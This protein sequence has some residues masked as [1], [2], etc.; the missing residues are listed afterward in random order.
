MTHN[1]IKNLERLLNPRH[2]AIIGGRD[3]EVVI[4]ECRRSGYDGPIWPVNPNREQIGGLRC[5]KHIQDLPAPPDAV[6]LAVPRKAAIECIG[7]LRDRGAGGVVCYTAGFGETGDAGAKAEK[8]LIEA[9]GD[10]ALVGPNCYGVINYHRGLALWPFA[11]GGHH[12]GFGAAIV[13]QSG[14]FSSD[15]TM[16]QR[17]L[18]LSY[19]VSAGN[20]S[21]LRLEDFVNAFIEQDHVRAIGLHIEG[22]PDPAGFEKVALR[23]LACDIPIVALKTGSSQIGSQLTISH[24]GS[25]SGT[26]KT[27]SAFFDRLGIIRAHD[28]SHFL[29]T[30]K[31]LCVAGKPS[32]RRLA[33][34]TCSGG[35]ATMLADYAE[36]LGLSF[37]QPSTTTKTALSA[38]LP[39][40]ATV[41]NPLDYTTP[42]WGIT[43]KTHPV[44][45]ATL[46]DGYDA[47]VIVQDYPAAGLDESKPYYQ[48]DADSFIKA[49]S[50][51]GIPSAICSTIHEN[52]DLETRN[53]LITHNVAPMQGINECLHAVAAA[54]NYR[55]RRDEIM[56]HPAVELYPTMPA[57]HKTYM[58]NELAG[59]QKLANS[60]VDIPA[61]EHIH[62]GDKLEKT[63]L[64]FPL[65]LK[66]LSPDLAHKTEAGAVQLG[67]GDIESLQ[68]SV[69]NMQSHIRHTNPF[70]KQDGFLIEEMVSDVI[71]ELMVSVRR[72]PQFGLVLMLSSGGIMAEL[73]DDATTLIL[74]AGRVSMMR[75]L[76]SLRISKLIEGYRGKG[77]VDKDKLL[78]CLEQIVSV[79]ADDPAI[80]EIEIN[81][82]MLTANKI[83]AVDAVVTCRE[84]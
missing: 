83:V 79:I 80:V 32:G 81:P 28:P 20:Q 82:I 51:A 8:S 1:R 17:S 75:A 55:E 22:L 71:A 30:L 65:A 78:D 59:K 13:T 44:F 23:A 63:A 43:E 68:I 26:D 34:F 76:A 25:M 12:P 77:S 38:L 14:M 42:I 54:T 33:G 36:P 24:T 61:H 74:P 84:I 72:D 11:H 9:A 3:A 67:I 66:F 39:H 47:A 45:V 48:S 70:I 69:A 4:K 53:Y 49:T 62:T 57:P 19:M 41:S 7:D 16:S 2:V 58:L 31:F 21:V 50:A 6:F 73:F 60:C 29:E 56:Q 15:L 52:L 10:L 27:Y 37:P 40:T 35:G 46:A 18:P 64:S 5:F